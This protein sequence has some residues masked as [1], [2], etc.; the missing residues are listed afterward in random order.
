M[1]T[2]PYSLPVSFSRE[3]DYVHPRPGGRVAGW[4]ESDAAAAE[5][6]FPARARSTSDTDCLR[7]TVGV[8]PKGRCRP[9]PGA[10]G[11]RRRASRVSLTSV[12][13]CAATASSE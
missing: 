12:L 5:N 6:V 13:Q 9:E 8:T 4:P 10:T 7:T 1:A 3:V 2:E 11:H